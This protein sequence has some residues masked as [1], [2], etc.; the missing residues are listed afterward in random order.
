MNPDSHSSIVKE[1]TPEEASKF[2]E[3]K[4]IES[5]TLL[6]VRQPNEYK[7][8]HIPGSILIPLSELPDRISELDN[9][10][11]VITYCRSGKRSY[12]AAVFLKD[13]GFLDVY[14]IKGGM[15]SWNGLEAE[16][17]YELGLSL[18]PSLDAIEDIVSLSWAM[19]D[20][21]Y[22]FYTGCADIINDTKIK[23]AF[24]Q[25]SRFEVKH[26]DD[27]I[28]FCKMADIDEDKIQETAR[29][30]FSDIM[31]SGVSISET[32]QSIKKS[33]LLHI[34]ILEWSMQLEINAVDLYMKM[35][36]LTEDEEARK[37]LD[38]IIAD[39]KAHLKRI[40]DL[41]DKITKN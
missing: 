10:I 2:I 7:Q 5:F 41:L 16:G 20:G 21:A 33:S 25:L 4:P 30:R 6:D 39:E 19:E 26:K 9:Q 1:L 11:P 14:S 13:S 22:R 27:V 8:S 32:L 38:R 29:S 24:I 18:I 34:N 15:N 37:L 17:D 31:E 28:S 40:G 35:H 36:R 3:N 12:A 23:E